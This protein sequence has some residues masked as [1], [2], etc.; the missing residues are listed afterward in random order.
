MMKSI[1][2]SVKPQQVFDILYRKKT[3][4]LRKN[5][6]K[7]F[8][9]WVYI[10]CNKGKFVNGLRRKEDV[11]VNNNL[12]LLNGKVCARFW[13]DE[14]T[15]LKYGR[16]VNHEVGDWNYRGWHDEHLETFKKLCLTEKQVTDYGDHSKLYAWHIKK[17]EV[18]DEPTPE[19]IKAPKSWEYVH[20][21]ENKDE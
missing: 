14:Y 17:L 11:I 4:E 3:L 5:V 20:I 12:K 10:Y 19:L 8:K 16:W 6:P 9:G 21:K 18:F 15:I 7:D 2:L 13:F 1:L